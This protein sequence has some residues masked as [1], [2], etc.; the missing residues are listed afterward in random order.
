MWVIYK[1]K[2]IDVNIFFEKIFTKEKGVNISNN[3]EKTFIKNINKSLEIKINNIKIGLGYWCNIKNGDYIQICYKNK[4]YRGIIKEAYKVT[5]RSMLAKSDVLLPFCKPSIQTFPYFSAIVGTLEAYN[6]AECWIYNNY[7]L[8]WIMRGEAKD[9]Y[10]GDFKYGDQE[11]QKDFCKLLNREIVLR[12]EVEYKYNNII[13][14][15]IE[16]INQE[17]YIYLSVDTYFIKEW[18]EDT[19]HFHCRHQVYIYGYNSIGK[20]VVLADFV[21]GKYKSM[22][23]PFKDFILAYNELSKDVVLDD[24][25]G[26][27][28]WL[29]SYNKN[30]RENINIGRINKLL[31]NFLNSEDTYIKSYLWKKEYDGKVI[32]GI[33]FYDRFY[34]MLVKNKGNKIDIRIVHI[35][36]ELNR[37]MLSRIHYIEK[38][39]NISFGKECKDKVYELMLGTNI[40][41]NMVLKYNITKN[42][43][44]YIK[45]ITKLKL[46]KKMQYKAFFLCYM[47]FDKI[48]NV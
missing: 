32:F 25:Y 48:L 5:K 39:N 26:Q 24:V 22:N 8:I 1:N 33:N 14:F 37:I 45:I 46:L 13:S 31:V 44:N 29:L 42:E 36:V 6:N 3:L 30:E 19:Q 41:Q 16:A 43:E 11:R 34:E 17:K 40:F 27:D 20:Y 21:N 12:S 7:I 10:W 9:G 18:W 28:N 23:V 47:E 35:L 38:S 2:E 15:I 4:S